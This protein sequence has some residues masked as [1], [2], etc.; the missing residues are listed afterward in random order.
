MKK[1]N[2]EVEEVLRRVIPIE[3]NSIDEALDKVK[4]Q[5][6][7]E[8]IVLDS[9]DYCQTSFDNLYSKKLEEPMDIYLRFNPSDNILT[10]IKDDDK[11][12]KYICDTVKEVDSCLRNYLANYVEDPEIEATKERE[13][14]ELER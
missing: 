13:E 6:D 1:Y 3:A 4:E 9:N 5:Y 10:I 2:I 14:Y 8:E 11:E 7:E 12:E